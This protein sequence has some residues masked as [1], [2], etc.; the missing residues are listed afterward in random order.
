MLKSKNT[1]EP[2]LKTFPPGVLRYHMHENGMD[3][4]MDNPKI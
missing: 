1:F 4:Q 2:N 3:G